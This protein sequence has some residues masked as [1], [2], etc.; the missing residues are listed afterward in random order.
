MASPRVADLNGRER[1][2]VALDFPTARE[3]LK[4]AERLGDTVS[5][6]KVGWEL[7]IAGGWR[8]VVEELHEKACFVDLKLPGDIDNTIVRL[9]RVCVDQLP[10][11]KFLT[12]SEHVRV[13]IVEAAV[14]ARGTS[15]EP[16]LLVVP[17]FSNMDKAGFARALGQ[18]P[19]QMVPYMI[20]RSDRLLRAGCD[21][22]IVSGQEIGALAS[23]FPQAIIVSPGIRPAGAPP[24]DHKRSTTPAE[25]I[26][27]GADF[28]VVGR[29]ISNA[30][31]KKKAAKDIIDE[32]D[33]A[34]AVRRSSGGS[35]FGPPPTFPQ[36][37]ACKPE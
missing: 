9:I 16:K 18:E 29:P 1:L 15:E 35:G 20:E 36:S 19:D 31:D 24:D 10:S 34:L 33:R 37:L 25:A 21:G 17:I 27:L 12:L 30:P 11:V 26:A 2:I 14:D 6:F 22:L 7:F 8:E 32:I 28:L 5:F 4:F 3:S 13:N 23:T